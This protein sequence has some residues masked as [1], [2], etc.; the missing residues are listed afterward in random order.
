MLEVEAGIVEVSSVFPVETFKIE[1][2]IP[3][4]L[5]AIDITK[6]VPNIP[7]KNG[8]K[9]DFPKLELPFEVSSKPLKKSLFSFI[10]ITSL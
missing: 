5:K 3:G 10:N 8:I 9:K 6:V 1:S 7:E 4:T 2:F